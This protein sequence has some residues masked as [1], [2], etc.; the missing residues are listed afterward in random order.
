MAPSDDLA[1]HE[2]EFGN[3]LDMLRGLVNNEIPGAHQELINAVNKTIKNIAWVSPA[4]AW[5]VHH[6]ASD[7]AK[8]LKKLLDDILT[9]A[10]EII[11][12]SLPVLSLFKVAFAW[13]DNV[14][15]P[16]SAMSGVAFERSQG[17][18]GWKGPAADAYTDKRLL[19]K[20]AIEAT[21]QNAREIALY[22][23]KVAEVNVTF[24]LSLL[25][26]LKELLQSIVAAVVAALTVA[27]VLEA[28]GKVADIAGKQLGAIIDIIKAA[29][30]Q[31]TATVS[32]AI[33]AEGTLNNFNA[34]PERKWPQV[35]T[36]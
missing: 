29:A 20:L 30:T 1:K 36:R 26:P 7:D 24:L 16:V 13:G 35:E 25:N 27:G 15:G 14:Q 32:A 34:F 31:L 6:R 9:K 3:A 33:T 5:Y 22:L 17:V 2:S 23:A 11:D 21:G 10:K 8:R 19:Q 28:I 18:Y 4:G 12:Q